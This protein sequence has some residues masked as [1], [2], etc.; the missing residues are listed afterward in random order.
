VAATTSGR[1]ASKVRAV[2]FDFGNVVSTVDTGRFLRKLADR[3][4]LSIPRL[5]AEIYDSGL[6]ARYEAGT[7]SSP[8]FYRC[9]IARTGAEMPMPE[10]VAAYTDLF[11]PIAGTADLIRRL[12]SRY[13]VGLLSNTNPLHFRH[14]I[15]SSPPFPCF[16]TVTLSYRVKTL[17]PDPRIYADAVSKLGVPAGACVYIDDIPEYAEGARL[18]GLHGLTFAGVAKLEHDLLRLGVRTDETERQNA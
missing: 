8:A 2:I 3:S 17:K 11:A 5:S 14:H 7:I 16:S 6:H 13:P 9:V 18:A 1:G 10:F 15:R 4:P 12:A